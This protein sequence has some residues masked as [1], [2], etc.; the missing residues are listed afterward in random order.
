MVLWTGWMDL[1]GSVGR[2]ESEM[3][4]NEQ[5]LG[6]W[7]FA[8]NWSRLLNFKLKMNLWEKISRVPI[9][10]TSFGDIWPSSVWEKSGRNSESKLR[11]RWIVIIFAVYRVN[12]QGR[13]K[14]H[15]CGKRMDDNYMHFWRCPEEVTI[16]AMSLRASIRI[17]R[18]QCKAH[19]IVIH[20]IVKEIHFSL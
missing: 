14:F 16:L 8:K 15:A 10:D 1:L 5:D 4:N 20:V 19:F 9:Y 18:H 6:H 3:K 12:R 11:R 17:F 2:K 13:S 7:D